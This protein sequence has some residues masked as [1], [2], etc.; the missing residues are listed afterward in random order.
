MKCTFR[1][2]L[3]LF[4][5]TSA[6]NLIA[7]GENFS[8]N[9]LKPKPGEAITINY[10]PAGTEL[11]NSTRIKMV[12]YFYSKNLDDTEEYDLS[13]K[14]DTW[15][16]K[17]TT[18]DSTCGV[19]VLF[20]S[21]EEKDNNKKNGYII[22]LFGKNG[23]MVR[24]SI[25]GLASGYYDWF[26][27]LGIDA[28]PQKAYSSFQE[29]FFI[30]PEL[31]KDYLRYYL[32]S[33]NQTQ[34]ENAKEVIL[35]EL[36]N[37]ESLPNLNETDLETLVNWYDRLKVE[38][39]SQPFKDKLLQSYPNDQYAQSQKYI[40]YK[41]QQDVEGKI[42][43]FNEFFE[44]FGSNGF[45]DYMQSD[46]IRTIVGSGDFSKAKD[47]VEGLKEPS[48]SSLN[49]VSW[50][51]FSKGGDINVAASLAKK[52]VDLAQKELD[53]PKEK[54]PLVQTKKEWE[55]LRKSS[56]GTIL[57]TYGAILIKQDKK[58]EALNA[59]SKSVELTD[60]TQN[61]INQR[62]AELLVDLGQFEKAKN[63]LEI[64][65]VSGKSKP[66][67]KDLLKK[68]FQETKGTAEGF[69]NY[70]AEIDLKAKGN[71]IAK[72]KK[73]M[74]N[75]PAQQFTLTD[76]NGKEVSLS[77]FKGKTVI[78]DFWATWCGPCVSSF[79]GMKQA[80]EKF[81][82]DGN[83]EFLFVN[84]WENADD[85]KQNAAEFIQKNNYPFHVLLDENNEVISSF[86]V[87][88]IP[89]KF[90]I[91]K[92]GNIRYKSIGFENTEAMIDEIGLIIPLIK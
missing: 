38:G 52:G 37:I 27:Y 36:K 75:E 76:L 42:K 11:E 91:D 71:A 2:L 69:E 21:G 67:M 55:D 24:G 65:I 20:Y 14:D 30:Y 5:I 23:K 89:T 56:L 26:Y 19:V 48:I 59:L 68:A 22:N 84:A 90:F 66:E 44:K 4:S 35:N 64:Y 7:A 73:E 15:T 33:I 41:S 32:F 58:D 62:Y 63:E 83:V 8:F 39:K 77:D 80:L 81:G 50:G 29:E 6:T 45:S 88:G 54:K 82:G 57:D 72:I 53:N 18:S 92:N 13:K 60:R 25:A 49:S 74:I 10:N 78:V 86:K 12:A 47:F 1:L 17:I 46:I 9:P 31:K 3:I 79:P 28:D 34:Q 16:G 87:S 43:L 51:I 40:E 61:V 85:K 70:Y